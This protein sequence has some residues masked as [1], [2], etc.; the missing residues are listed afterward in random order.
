MAQTTLKA[1]KG[2]GRQQKSAG[3]QK[4]RVTRAAT[5]IKKGPKH[6]KPKGNNLFLANQ[7]EVS[8]SINKKNESLI[9]GRAVEGGGKFF[10]GDIKVNAKEEKDKKKKQFEM[11]GKNKMQSRLKRQLEQIVTKR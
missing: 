3:A 7:Q 10:L 1:S 4:R 6:S 2:G 11:S 8:K 5:K 9:G